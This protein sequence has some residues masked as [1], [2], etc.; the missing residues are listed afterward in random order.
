MTLMPGRPPILLFCAPFSTN[1]PVPLPN[2]AS[3]VESVTDEV[4]GNGL[5][6][7]APLISIPA[8]RNPPMSKF[9]TWYCSPEWSGHCLR[10]CC[11]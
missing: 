5:R 1:T 2:A 11:H 10:R 4:A 6:A 9:D 3:P 7:E 8:F